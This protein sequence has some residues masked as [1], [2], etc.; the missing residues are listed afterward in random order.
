MTVEV[1]V[2]G[3]VII[4]FLFHTVMTHLINWM[5]RDSLNEVTGSLTGLSIVAGTV[6][7]A[8]CIGML[9]YYVNQ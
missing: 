1:P 8:I 5:F 4:V 3:I 7:V 6:E 9:N 2:L